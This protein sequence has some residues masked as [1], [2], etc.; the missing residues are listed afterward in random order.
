[1]IA[2][3]QFASV[4][5][6][7]QVFFS[8]DDICFGGGHLSEKYRPFERQSIIH[9]SAGFATHLKENKNPH[10]LLESRNF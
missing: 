1:M 3:Q 10:S 2:V 7:E 8:Q 9:L 5:W 4:L 6:R